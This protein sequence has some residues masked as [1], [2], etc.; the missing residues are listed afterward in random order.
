MLLLPLF[1]VERTQELVADLTRLQKSGAIPTVPIFLDSPLAIQITKVFRSHGRE[2]EELD[3]SPSLLSSSNLRFTETADES[4][5][6][7]RVSGGAIIIAAS[8]MCDAGRIR[9]HLKR[10]LWSE[11]ATVLLAGYQ[12]PG[13][14][15]RL[16]ADG[17]SAVKIQG[18]DIN[19]RATIRQ[20][21]LYSGHADGEELLEW[22]R[23]RQPVKRAL[24][25]VHG[26]NDEVSALRDALIKNG[27]PASHVI[28]PVLDDEV[29][30]LGDGTTPQLRPFPRRLLPENIGRADWHNDLAQ[31]S[32]DLRDTFER[33]A[34]DR[35]RAELIR[36][37]RRALADH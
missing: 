5:A 37:L 33:A 30:L 22:I 9:H 1:A 16:L 20:T 6:I 19:V 10:W 27:M 12:A 23:R 26:E 15:G 36:R 8:G 17:V 7:E 29:E 4:R 2:L 11:K 28:V 3:K 13:T 14:L 34:D 31:F 32:L 25:L 18:D 35:S 24:Y 21:D